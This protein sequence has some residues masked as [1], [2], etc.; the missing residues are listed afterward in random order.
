MDLSGEYCPNHQG[1]LRRI[2][3]EQSPTEFNEYALHPG[4]PVSMPREVPQMK[5]LH[6]A[7]IE[8]HELAKPHPP[9]PHSPFAVFNRHEQQ[10]CSALRFYEDDFAPLLNVC[11]A[12]R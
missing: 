3:S 5:S 6:Y 10:S 7:V 8:P 2:A 11:C 12:E 4:L 9:V 1:L